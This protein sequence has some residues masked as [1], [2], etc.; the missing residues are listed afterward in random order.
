M[1]VLNVKNVLKSVFPVRAEDLDKKEIIEDGLLKYLYTYTLKDGTVKEVAKI[2]IEPVREI[3]AIDAT[4]AKEQAEIEAK[5][6]TVAKLIA[7][8]E[9]LIQKLPEIEATK[10]EEVKE[11]IEDVKELTP[12]EI[13][14]IIK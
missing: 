5:Q 9:T 4:I 8:K 12:E 11:P 3:E 13:I 10:I 2:E 14:E 1:D 6:A 7:E